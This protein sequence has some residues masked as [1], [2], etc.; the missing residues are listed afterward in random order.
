MSPGL[1][2]GLKILVFGVPVGVYIW[3]L[4]RVK[5]PEL[6]PTVMEEWGRA[7]RME[8]RLF[9]SLGLVILAAGGS[10]FL[11]AGMWAVYAVMVA[12]PVGVVAALVVR[13]KR[14]KLER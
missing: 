4:V 1:I 12:V 3:R 10:I 13:N 6:S 5:A 2:V 11:G 9:T 7:R 8:L 14:E